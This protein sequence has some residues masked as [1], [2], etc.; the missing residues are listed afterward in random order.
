MQNNEQGND[1]LKEFEPIQLELL[2]DHTRQL[3]NAAKSIFNELA[4]LI[5][6]ITLYGAKHQSS[7]NFRTRFF[8]VIT[9]ALA[10]G[11]DITVEVQTYAFVLADQIIY[12]DP[13]VDGNFIYKFYT[14]GLRS[15][16]FKRG[17]S[18]QE[19]DKLLNIFLLDWSNPALFEDDSVTMIWSQRFENIKYSVA[20]GYNEDTQEADTYYFNFT[21]EL[22]R[23]IDYCHT[24][25]DFV[26]LPSTKL[27]WTVEEQDRVEKLIQVSKRELL[28]KLISLSHETQ[29]QWAQVGGV[30]RFVQLSE[31]LAQLFAQNGEISELERMM[32]QAFYIASEK[33][34]TQLLENWTVPIFMQNL[35]KPLQGQDDP[36][37]L[38]ALA[39][40][41]LLGS[42]ATPYI[43][44]G[45]GE[46]A[47]HHL[48][49][50]SQMMLPHIDQHPI[51]LCRVVKTATYLHNKKLIP[52]LYTSQNDDLC[53]KVFQ[54][55]WSHED[56]G[57]RYEGL[58]NLPERL[59][60]LPLLSEALIQGLSD[61][62]SKIRTLAC[63]RLS[64]LKDESSRVALKDKL[65]KE[66]KQ[67]NS[68]HLHV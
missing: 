59:Y 60:D 52:L 57:V 34:C 47:E 49:T 35:F 32:R 46:A 28:E 65:E 53:I 55:S 2:D 10:K 31:Q 27:K 9:Q 43:A 20:D 26:I 11:D 56:Q 30:D 5:K 15:L 8:E 64:K 14:D 6:S 23:L 48:D 29:S 12:E 63:F 1:L 39:C 18:S 45:M 51:E 36:S 42:S 62:Y 54:T 25:N 68:S 38:S 17:I 58:L 41:Q 4:R 67:K 40:I 3:V 33:Q 37:S 7:L 16:T 50:L 61:P 22:N 13:K 44:K 24:S 21:D 19:V 66:A